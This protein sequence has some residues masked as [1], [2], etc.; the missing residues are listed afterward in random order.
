[1]GSPNLKSKALPS[2]GLF[3]S[4]QDLSASTASIARPPSALKR[5]SSAK[6]EELRGRRER[7]LA[8]EQSRRQDPVARLKLLVV[9][10]RLLC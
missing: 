5:R 1:M 6:E 10:I 8:I 2:P 7:E 9:C 4:S 3:G